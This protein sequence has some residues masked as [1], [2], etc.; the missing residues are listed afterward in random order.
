MKRFTL[1]RSVYKQNEK[2]TIYS[3]KC[4]I[5]CLDD[6]KSAVLFDHVAC[7]YKNGHRA[8]DDFIKSDVVMMDLDNGHTDD[9]DKWKD[10]D[11]IVEAFPDVE[12]YYIQSRNHMKPKKTAAGEIKEPR[13]KYHIYFPVEAVADPAEYEKLKGYIGAMFPY[14]DCKCRDVAHFFYAVSVAE[15]GEIE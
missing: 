9:P 5:S 10:I 1:Y 8:K 13:P 2:N 4:L 6:L 7:E 12:F 11:D 15:G 14:F 3:N